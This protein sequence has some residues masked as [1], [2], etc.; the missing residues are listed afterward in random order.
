MAEAAEWAVD[1]VWAEDMVA[2]WVVA[3]EAVKNAIAAARSAISLE[4]APCL[5]L[6]ATVKEAEVASAVATVATRAMA[7]EVGAG[8]SNATPVVDM[9]IWR[10]IVNRDRSVT[11]VSL[12]ALLSC[13]YHC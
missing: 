8:D 1:K 11:T 5:P 4:T 3:V 2:A 9:V 12:W 10:V 6:A 13:F 7:V